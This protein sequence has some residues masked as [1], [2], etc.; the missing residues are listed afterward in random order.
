MSS[1]SQALTLANLQERF[2]KALREENPITNVLATLEEKTKVNREYLAYGK[3]PQHTRFNNNHQKKKEKTA[4]F[5]KLVFELYSCTLH[6][7]Q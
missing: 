5:S 2:R 1:N 4:N 3:S 7:K 6:K